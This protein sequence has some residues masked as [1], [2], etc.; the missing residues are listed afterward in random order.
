MASICIF[1]SVARKDQDSLSDKDALIMSDGSDASKL[2][3]KQWIGQGWS[4]ASYTENR[5]T[6]MA[7]AGSLFVQHLKQEGILYT[8]PN[9]F[10]RDTLAAYTPKADYSDQITE[11]VSALQLL[12]HVPPTHELDY[13][14]ADLLH[15]LIRNLGILKLANE[16]IYEY[17]FRNIAGQLIHLGIICADDMEAFNGLRYAKTSYRSGKIPLKPASAIVDDGLRIVDK[18]CGVSLERSHALDVSMPCLNQPYFNLRGIEKV[19]VAYNGLPK[20]DASLLSDSEAHIWKRVMDPRAYSWDVKTKQS[21]LWQL[22]LKSV[23][24]ENRIRLKPTAYRAE[25]E[26][27]I[28]QR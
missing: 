18:L 3:R 7:D 21:E 25:V 16:G 26:N 28:I 23:N 8:D 4:V 20:P 12:E 5:L 13:W 14:S 10:L 9:N 17:S 24:T 27:H 19:L 15:V 22:L 1:G 2:L 6:K 11:T